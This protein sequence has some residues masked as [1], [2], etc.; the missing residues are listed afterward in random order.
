MNTQ[1]KYRCPKCKKIGYKIVVLYPA[2][3]SGIG[4]TDK[5]GKEIIYLDEDNRIEDL[6][7]DEEKVIYSCYNC[8]YEFNEKTI[9]EIFE[10]YAIQ[11]QPNSG[12]LPTNPDVITDL[13]W[14]GLGGNTEKLK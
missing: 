12:T 4:Y 13:W 2:V 14:Y 1:A 8:Y 6:I 3:V 7:T 11:K 5:D 9:T 10:K